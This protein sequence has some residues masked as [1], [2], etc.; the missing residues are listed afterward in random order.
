[1]CV[2]NKRPILLGITSELRTSSGIEIATAWGVGIDQHEENSDKETLLLLN[3]Y[4]I[5]F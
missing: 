5:D 1:M 3:I 4:Q 2:F